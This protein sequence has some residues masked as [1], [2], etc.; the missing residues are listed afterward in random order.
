[1]GSHEQRPSRLSVVWFAHRTTAV[2]PPKPS[3]HKPAYIINFPITIFIRLGKSVPPNQPNCA[4]FGRSMREIISDP[5]STDDNFATKLGQTLD[6]VRL[7]D[8][9][10]SEI[11]NFNTFVTLG[12]ENKDIDVFEVCDGRDID[13]HQSCPFV[14]S[15]IAISLGPARATYHWSVE[16]K[17][18]VHD[19]VFCAYSTPQNILSQDDCL[20]SSSHPKLFNSRYKHTWSVRCYKFQLGLINTREVSRHRVHA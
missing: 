10:S 7:Y 18:I 15:R 5:N 12:C 11:R 16:N 6:S 4:R 9:P 20:N 14:Q 1:L 17:T 13:V 2:S 19:E 8:C 3:I